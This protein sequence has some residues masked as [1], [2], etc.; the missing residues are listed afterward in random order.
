MCREAISEFGADASVPSAARR[1]VVELI[2]EAFIE[3]AGLADDVALVVT[4]LLTNTLRAGS[5]RTVLRVELHRRQVRV[6]VHDDAPGDPVPRQAP[7]FAVNGRGLM[8]VGALARDW[9][10]V[11]ED[12]GKAVWAELA[13]PPE[14]I[15][16][17]D[18][19]LAS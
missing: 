15:T 9:G 11:H 10:V 6:S 14:A 12:G 19:H 13:V 2:D 8:I 3:S 17:L 7:P 18:C 16:E 4:E 1:H 5:T